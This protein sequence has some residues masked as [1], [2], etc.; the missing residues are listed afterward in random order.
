MSLKVAIQGGQASFHDMAVRQYF[1]GHSIELCECRRFRQQ[2]IEVVEKN[3]DCAVMA[4]ENSLS[5]SFLANYTLLQEFPLRITGEIYLR[6]QQNL[7]ALPGQAL[8]DIQSVHSHPMALHQCSNFLDGHTQIRCVET[9]DTAESAREISEKKLKGVAAIAST[10]AAELY[11]LNILAESIENI[12]DNYTRFL[13]LSK[14]KGLKDPSADK[15]S[16][17]FHVRHEVGALAKVLTIF[18]EHSV[19]IGLIQSIPI[20]GRPNEYEFHVDVEWQN[21]RQFDQAIQQVRQTAME[22]KILGE[23]QSGVKPYLS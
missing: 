4:I 7:M 5:G 15:A 20:P 6:I 22:S 21:R 13:V 18:K 12:K 19:N 17:S 3:V 2:C 16:L 9:F 23:Y 10:F 8:S 14:E 1:K 11:G